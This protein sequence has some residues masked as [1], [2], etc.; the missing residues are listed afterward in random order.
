V[1]LVSLIADFSTCL[2]GAAHRDRT[3]HMLPR[4]L[5]RDILLDRVQR[6]GYIRPAPA[7]GLAMPD[8]VEIV[9]VSRLSTLMSARQ[10]ERRKS[11]MH[12]LGAPHRA[13]SQHDFNL[14]RQA[15]SATI[16]GK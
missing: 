3:V 7:S 15:A 2:L 6:L 9:T 10:L 11:P 13:D 1:Q 8:T 4:Q 5:L 16:F 14:F 12:S